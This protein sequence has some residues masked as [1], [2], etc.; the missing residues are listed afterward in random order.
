MVRLNAV[1]CRDWYM[2]VSGESNDKTGAEKM[3]PAEATP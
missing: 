3:M 2:Q 1:N